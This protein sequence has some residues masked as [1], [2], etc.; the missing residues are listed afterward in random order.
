MITA[1]ENVFPVFCP[2]SAN[3]DK[4]PELTFLAASKFPEQIFNLLKQ[5]KSD[6]NEDIITIDD[7]CCE[8]EDTRLG[9]LFNSYG[10]DKAINGHSRIFSRI[11][12]EQE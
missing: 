8:S 9:A 5:C 2:N 3:F 12:A 4:Y 10:S 6:I 11:F 1:I 7:F